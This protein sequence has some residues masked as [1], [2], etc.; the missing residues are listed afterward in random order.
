MTNRGAL[1]AQGQTGVVS[2]DGE[3]VMI[4]RKGLRARAMTRDK[5]RRIPVSS[6]SHVQW[7]APGFG[8]N[9][10]VSFLMG[11]DI[12]R[13]GDRMRMADAAHDEFTV[14]FT[15]KQAAEFEQI[16]DAVESAITAFSRPVQVS[17]A[18]AESP[19]EQLKQLADLHAAGIV[20]DE[21]FAAKKVELLGRM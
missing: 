4:E 13:R 2:F 20:S 5:G 1:S 17:G 7:E 8:K 19:A 16:R 14:M 10:W 9:G 15:K 3:F 18:P 11:Q 6:L 12:A 21:E